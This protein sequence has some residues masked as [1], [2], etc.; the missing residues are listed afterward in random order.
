MQQTKNKAA[1]RGVTCLALAA[2]A[3][4]V[5]GMHHQRK[6]SDASVDWQQVSTA[7][8][9]VENAKRDLHNSLQQRIVK[10]QQTASLRQQ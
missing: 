1:R 5:A 2:I 3:I 7:L 8:M 9:E 4:C 10:E 6:Q